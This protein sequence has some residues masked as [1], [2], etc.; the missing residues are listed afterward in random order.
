ME[1]TDQALESRHSSGDGGL[2]V[3]H[4]YIPAGGRIAPAVL[5]QDTVSRVTRHHATGHD[6]QMVA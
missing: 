3:E 4:F 1:G 2:P 6:G 5:T